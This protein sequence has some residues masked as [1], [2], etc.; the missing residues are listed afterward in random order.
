MLDKGHHIR[1][2]Y[3]EL[4]MGPFDSA[5][6]TSTFRNYSFVPDM[7][8]FSGIFLNIWSPFPNDMNSK[9][10]QQRTHWLIDFHNWREVYIYLPLKEI[11]KKSLWMFKK[12]L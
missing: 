1:L 11:I 8:F 2:I 6:L 5:Q 4:N 3:F 9:A 12:M 7:R 10:G